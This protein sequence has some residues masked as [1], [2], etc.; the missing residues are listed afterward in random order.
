VFHAPFLNAN[1]G[2]NLHTILSSGDAAAIAYP[3]V[4]IVRSFDEVLEKKEIDLVAICSP[5][6][7]HFDQTKAVLEAG[8]HAV[9]E[10][11]ITATYAEALELLTV[12]E[13]NQKIIFPYHNRRWDGDFMTIQ[14]ILSE[15]KLGRVHD[16]ISS[17]D[18]FVPDVGR[19]SWRYQEPYAGGTLYDL[20]VHMIDQAIVLFGKP[21]AVFCRLFNQRSGSIADDAFDLKL[22]Y[23]DLNVTLKAGVFVKEP[24]PRFIIHGT[25]GS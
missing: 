16:F 24:G 15:G 3:N 13:Q 11:P 20:G 22:I 25:K 7:F 17:F 1:S 4:H 12:A 2:F 10:K 6:E 18:R 14:K 23:S 8:K 5:N 21:S 9:L 19:A